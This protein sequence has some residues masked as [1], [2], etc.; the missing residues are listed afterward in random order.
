MA[1]C[2]SL[3]RC[4][5]AVLPF[6]VDA[7]SRV[8][9]PLRPSWETSKSRHDPEPAEAKGV[10]V[11]RPPIRSSLRL[12]ELTL[13]LS[14]FHIEIT[15]VRKSRFAFRFHELCFGNIRIDSIFLTP[16][17]NRYEDREAKLPIKV[18]LILERR[19][20]RGDVYSPFRKL[21]PASIFLLLKR[22][23][24]RIVE[25]EFENKKRRRGKKEKNNCLLCRAAG[26]NLRS[27]HFTEKSISREIR[28]DT[29][30]DL[31][32]FGKF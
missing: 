16:R 18:Y 20:E 6:P 14:N 31:P 2:C 26:S 27:N 28:V 8:E 25:R 17:N 30:N 3:S 7:I 21:G 12:D 23:S 10:S 1:R 19:W 32:R 9:T 29:F 13:I 4:H 5:F 22:K 11:T 15:R 24:I